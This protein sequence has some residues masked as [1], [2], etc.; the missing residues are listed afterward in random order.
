MKR[1]KN[2]TDGFTGVR[3]CTMLV[4]ASLA[5]AGCAGKSKPVIDPTGVDMV[6]YEKDLAECEQIAQ[7]VEQ[8]A[9]EQAAGGALVTGAIGAVLGGSDGAKK[10]A[11]VGLIG[12][13]AKGARATNRERA[14]VVKNCLRS[15]DTLFSAMFPALSLKVFDQNTNRFRVS[16][17]IKIRSAVV[18]DRLF[19]TSSNGSN[20]KSMLHG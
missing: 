13:A 15:A 8:K 17:G 12:G 6:Q 4:L 18:S 3:F 11:G 1:L 2:A 5:A 14:R 20:A 16:C 7:Q 10:G 9:G 19:Q